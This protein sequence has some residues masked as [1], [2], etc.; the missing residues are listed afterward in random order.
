MPAA[1]R[2]VSEWWGQG[3]TSDPRWPGLVANRLW[4]GGKGRVSDGSQAFG[5][6]TWENGGPAPFAEGSGWGRAA[7][8]GA[9]D[10]P[11]THSVESLS[12]PPPRSPLWSRAQ[13]SER[14]PGH[15]VQG[16]RRQHSNPTDGRPAA[17]VAW[18]GW[19]GSVK[20]P[21][22]APR[23]SR[24]KQPEGG[25]SCVGDAGRVRGPGSRDGQRRPAPRAREVSCAARAEA[26]GR[27]GTRDVRGC[28][29]GGLGGLG[30]SSVA[31]GARERGT[32]RADTE[33]VC[34]RRC[35]HEDAVERGHQ[36]TTAGRVSV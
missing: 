25:G 1:G 26:E 12:H 20:R 35:F 10:P 4:G 5:P 8:E 30:G 32:G 19:N 18:G 14:G 31:R 3:Q 36:I 27:E 22:S 6:S 11:W 23:R 13:G 21:E 24:R 15:G 17:E 34:V 33:L 16:S 2:E 29:D 28:T 9:E 7:V